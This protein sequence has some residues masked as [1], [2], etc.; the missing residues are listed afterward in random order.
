MQVEKN[1]F[2]LLA[3]T[4]SALYLLMLIPFLKVGYG[5]EEDSWGL[6]M[7]AFEMQHSGIYHASRLPGHPIHE[8]ILWLLFPATPF[9]YN[10]VSALFAAGSL[11]IAAHLFRKLKIQQPLLAAI[12]LACIPVVMISGTYTIDYSM[13]LFFILSAWYFIAT[14]NTMLSAVMLAL[15][16]GTR[17]TNMYMI[18]PLF[19]YLYSNKF[20]LTCFIKLAA[21]SGILSVIFYAPVFM[22]YGKSFFDYSDQFPYP[23]FPKLL[24]KSNL[25][26]FGL[27][28]VISIFLFVFFAKRFSFKN[29]LYI[30]ISIAICLLAYLR[31]P[32]K[33]A[34]LIP[35]LP[36][37][38]ML[39]SE[40]LTEKRFMIFCVMI[41]LSGWCFG[42]ALVDA[43]RGSLIHNKNSFEIQGQSIAFTL[44]R[45]N[46]LLDVDK[47]KTK[48]KYVTSVLEKCDTLSK[49]SA[50]ISG[51]WYN[52]LLVHS[53]YSSVNKQAHF[54]FYCDE[55]SMQRLLKSNYQIYY[56]DEQEVYNDLMFQSAFTNKYA[57]TFV[58]K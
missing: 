9:K 35:M 33:S 16:V 51:W 29:N 57:G 3:A 43:D 34:Y 23:N 28:G 6:V 58:A 26:V 49:P 42:I 40:M 37:V 36:F 54:V 12:A 47:R 21:I 10:F 31:L 1:N 41:I 48:E 53:G 22:Q 7:N 8:Y 50:I 13:S 27:V 44:T 45:G 39:F 30:I 4:A 46:I 24:Y 56:L 17:I 25:G 32:Q 18:V 19:V 52:M 14:K 38:I 2:N 15:A 5:V 55:D 20:N 11:F